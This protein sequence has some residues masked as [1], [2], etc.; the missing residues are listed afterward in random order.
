[1]AAQV[2]VSL[3]LMI[4]GSMLIR[5]S[6]RALKMDTGYDSKHVVDLE[7]QFPEGPKYT[8]D[9]QPA[10]VREL[11]A[12]LAALPGVAAITTGRP[13]DGRRRTNGRSFAEWRKTLATKYA[14]DPLLTPT[15][16]RI[17]FKRWESRCSSA[18]AF[19]RKRASLSMSVIL[20]ESAAESLWPGQNPIGRSLRLAPAGSSTTRTN[21]YPMGQLTRSSASLATHAE[22]LLDGSDSQQI[23]MP[24]PEDRLQDYPILIRTNV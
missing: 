7:L 8:A 4:A 22:L 1:M 20:S 14:S 18:A 21:F 9:R 12:R 6:I 19:K 24:L 3:V 23:Y 5:S 11:R 13:P 17:T 2:A 10:L 15:F 16:S